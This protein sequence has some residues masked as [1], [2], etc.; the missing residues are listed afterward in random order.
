VLSIFH[1]AL[2]FDVC[3][4]DCDPRLMFTNG[5]GIWANWEVTGK[6]RKLHA[7]EHYDLYSLPNIF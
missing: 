7:E 1:V 2:I 3:D 4:C 5:E 6:W